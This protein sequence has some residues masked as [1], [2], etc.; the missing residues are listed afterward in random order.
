M[1]KTILYDEIITS[2]SS[3]AIRLYPMGFEL[4]IQCGTIKYLQM[5]NVV[6]VEPPLMANG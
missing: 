4:M 3:P 5:N 2:L 1:I 6:E